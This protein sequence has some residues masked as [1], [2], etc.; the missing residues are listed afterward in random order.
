VDV[1]TD[2]ASVEIP[3]PVAGVVA[4][5]GG[6]VGDT[7]AVGAELLAIEPA[8]PGAGAVADVDDA[9]ASSGNAGSEPAGESSSAPTREAALAPSAAPV[10]ATPLEP[11]AQPEQSQLSSAAASTAVDEVAASRVLASPSVRYRARQLGIDL[12]ALNVAADAIIGHGDLD[13]YLLQS[14]APAA[15]SSPSASTSS[16]LPS[17]P[18]VPARAPAQPVAAGPSL[19]NHDEPADQDIRL[20]GLR[21]QIATKMQTAARSIPHF[22]YV[23]EVDVTELEALRAQLNQ[24]ADEDQPRL[25]VLPFIIRAMVLAIRQYP[26]VNARFDEAQGVIHQ[27]GAV[28]LGMAAQTDRGLMVPVLRHVQRLDLWQC[29]DQVASMASLARRGRATRDQLSGSTITLTSLGSLGGIVST[30][31]IN[32]PEV[33][34]VGVNRIVERLVPQHGLAVPRKIMNLS[35]SFD[36]RIIDGMQ[37]AEFIQHI[38]RSLESPA[39]LFVNSGG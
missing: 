20:G 39:L 23:E 26:E 35:S 24:A 33:A 17:P 37:A 12:A 36:H 30:P 34:I 4:R 38:R 2:K 7:L 13:Q 25:T 19:A 16:T 14:R 1:M 5:L 22:S 28:H 10:A 9:D 31:I 29:A 11:D 15:V 6:E 27:S 32:H 21:R 18:S 8:A 3:A